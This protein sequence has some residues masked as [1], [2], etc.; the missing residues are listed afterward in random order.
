VRTDQELAG[1]AERVLRGN[2]L[3]EYTRPSPHLYP[4]QW[5]WDSAFI[6]I[7]W[8]HIDW[9][10]AV[11]EVDALLAAQWTNGM[12]PHIR[13]N[14]QVTDYAPGPEWWPD[15][16]VR[17][18]GERT[19]GIS[20]P[21]VLPTAV[22]QVGLLQ[23]DAAR[24]HAWWERTFDA[25]R[26]A[27]LFYP[28][29]RTTGG[30]PLIVLVHP[31]ESG[32]DNSPRWDFAT[33]L[34]YRPSRPYRRV[35]TSIVGAALRPTERDYDL[36]MYLVELL[37][38]GRYE[39]QPLL[40]HTPFAVYDALF[41]AVWYRA[42]V[43]LN[44]IAAELGKPPVVEDAAL[45]AFR[46]AY[47]QTLWYAPGLI[48]RDYDVRAQRQI[49]VDTVAG[50]IAIY[51]GFVDP[52]Q[53]GAMLTR[54]RVRSAECRLLPSVP[55]D[56]PEFEAARY[57]RGPVWVQI[58]WL[59]ARGLETLGLSA[60]AAAL[61]EE[62]LDLVRRAGCFEYFH[63]YTGEGLGGADFSW[64]AA[65]VLDLLRRPIHQPSSGGR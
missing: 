31:W 50:L 33:G 49:P 45:R 22:Y 13:Y 26:E 48:F 20:Q 54:Y 12:L 63:A 64:T 51:A 40:A 14:P 37:A 36:Y 65:L 7:G 47:L 6:A 18:P 16:P 19:S 41:N 9:S 27:V 3:G 38:A 46:D 15:V 61:A 2:D 32:L 55:P 35:D 57:W 8:A 24:R 58:N 39:L 43:D 28:R 11:R 53:A 4:H 52:E 44:R 60:E 1:Q 17:R 21:P 25:L 10:R 23:P 42:A 5:N 34:G 62:T 56:Q 29:H 59:V 30:S